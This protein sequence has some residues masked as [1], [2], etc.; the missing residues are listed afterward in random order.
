MGWK[1]RARHS[2]RAAAEPGCVLISLRPAG[3]CEPCLPQM[4]MTGLAAFLLTTCL[5]EKDVLPT[6]PRWAWGKA[7]G[8]PRP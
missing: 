5:E 6:L 8:R 3:E 4:R 2:V 1:G 7:H